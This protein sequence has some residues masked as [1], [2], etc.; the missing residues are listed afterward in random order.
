MTRTM[1]QSGWK[2]MVLW[3]FVINLGVAFGAGLYEAR[4]VIPG[5]AQSPPETWPNTGLLFWVYVTTVPLTLLT[6]AS[7]FAAW[8]TKGARRKW[9]LLAVVVI[10]VE[11][12]ATFSYFIP[13]MAGLMESSGLPASE[14]LDTLSTWMQ[15]NHGRHILTFTGWMAALK[16]LVSG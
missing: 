3:L 12:A 7:I 4:V 11:R 2:A 13:T 14:V 16:A 15:L 1:A 8:K 10:L 6:L 9:Y 5:F